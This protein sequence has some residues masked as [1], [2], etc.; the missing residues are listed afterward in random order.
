ML[1]SFF[2]VLLSNYNCSGFG[3]SVRFCV[4]VRFYRG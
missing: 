2:M 4:F 3:F 1:F